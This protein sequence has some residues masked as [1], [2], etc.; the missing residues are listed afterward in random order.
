LL[1]LKQI[2]RKDARLAFINADWRDFQNC[3][4][5]N[6]D[7]GQAILLVDYYDMFKKTGWT[8]THVIQAPM[9]SERFNDGVV[10]AMQ[11]KR[12]SGSPAGM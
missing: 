4:V 12:S 6:E 7:P 2:T 11:K 9:S 5:Q 8:L 1:F 10:S 3:P